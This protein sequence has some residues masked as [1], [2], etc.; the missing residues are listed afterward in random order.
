[1]LGLWD[2]AEDS[3][4]KIFFSQLFLPLH[5]AYG[6]LAPQSSNPCPLQWKPRVL[7]TDHQ[8]IPLGFL[9]E[10]EDS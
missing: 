1:M 3:F 5:M 10:E 7:T 8:G 2:R 9:V 6:I 4:K